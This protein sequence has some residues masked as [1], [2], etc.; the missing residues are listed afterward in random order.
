M[1]H[2]GRTLLLITLFYCFA[3]SVAAQGLTID[4]Y[5]GISNYQGD[6]QE[7]SLTLKNSKI[8]GGLGVHLPITDNW[9]FRGSVL[10]GQLYSTDKGGK[11]YKRNLDFYTDLFEIMGGIQYNFTSLSEKFT[12][13]LFA[14]LGIF[15]F[16][17]YT[18]DTSGNKFY[19]QPLSTEGQGFTKGIQSYGLTQF[20]IPFGA[21]VDFHLSDRWSLG[22]EIGFRKLFTDYLDD[23]SGTYIDAND[24]LTARG[25]KAV[26]LSYRGGE[27]NPLATYPPAGTRRGGDSKDWYYFILGKLS[28][29]IGSGGGGNR[30]DSKNMGC[31]ANVL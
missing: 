27:I 28:Y 15:H 8:A 31:P 10:Y 5:G 12:P 16:N 17:P 24:L 7:K 29:E 18:F 25:P 11:N 13:Y 30:K 1:T 3:Q 26:E 20:S 22:L 14:G 4:L 21:G 23:V 2:F 9:Q 19:L 6:L